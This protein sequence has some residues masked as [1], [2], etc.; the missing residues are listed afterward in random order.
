MIL[1]EK[2]ETLI[3]SRRYDIINEG[4]LNEDKQITVY[5]QSEYPLGTSIDGCQVMIDFFTSKSNIAV[6]K[7]CAATINQ[8]MKNGDLKI[9]IS[10]R[11]ISRL[12]YL[13]N[14]N[15]VDRATAGKINK[16]L[17]NILSKYTT[18]DEFAT[19][20][21][22]T[23]A[24]CISVKNFTHFEI[25]LITNPVI[26]EDFKYNV[27]FVVKNDDGNIYKYNNSPIC[28]FY[29]IDKNTGKEIC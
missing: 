27:K 24:H 12:Q 9:D 2:I 19:I 7:K 3:N 20:L 28:Y 18:L 15:K 1:N 25:E 22:T 17:N 21:K 29:I 23:H 14:N 6:A 10:K 13:A 16:N 8:G 11:I 4:F 26:V 5:M